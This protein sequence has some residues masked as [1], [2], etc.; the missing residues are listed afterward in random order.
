MQTY[1]STYNFRP[2]ILVSNW[3]IF[4][5]KN[6]ILHQKKKNENDKNLDFMMKNKQ[7]NKQTN[8][9]KQKTKKKVKKKDENIKQHFFITDEHTLK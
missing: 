3:L 9:Q 6:F 5:F 4:Y 1:S 8:K 7:T 2:P